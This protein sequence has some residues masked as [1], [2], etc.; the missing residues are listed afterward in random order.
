LL[1]LL[2]NNDPD[3]RWRFITGY[4]TQPLVE[5]KYHGKSNPLNALYEALRL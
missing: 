5:W 2:R 4:P 3:R 1:L